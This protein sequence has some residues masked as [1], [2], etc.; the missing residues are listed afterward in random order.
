MVVFY[1]KTINRNWLRKAHLN[2]CPLGSTFVTDCFNI[3]IQIQTKSIGKLGGVKKDLED[4]PQG[5]YGLLR[6]Q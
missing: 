4:S 2:E 6:I 5:H 1:S 3:R